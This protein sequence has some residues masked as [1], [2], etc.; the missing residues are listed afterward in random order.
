M[1]N[2]ER[3]IIWLGI[4]GYLLSVIGYIAR[5]FTL[6]IY[7]YSFLFGTLLVTSGYGILFLL[8]VKALI[9]IKQ[10]ETS[11]KDDTQSSSTSSDDTGL[12]KKGYLL[13][14]AFFA[15]IHIFPSLTERIRYYDIF[16]AMGYL[17]SIFTK[18]L[19][20]YIPLIVLMIYYISGSYQKIIDWKVS[21]INKLQFISRSILIFY[22]GL[23]LF[24]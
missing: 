23:H 14:F 19:P 4:I 1:E 21:K 6:D 20:Y 11:K 10:E 12:L 22:Y 5:V 3:I 24:P 18:Y 13:L 15:G 16:A 17:L 7:T 8:N 9:K 2:K